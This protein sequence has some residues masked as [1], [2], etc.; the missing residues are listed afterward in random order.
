MKDLR[1]ITVTE[2]MKR[3][4]WKRG[5]VYRLIA[6]R[7]LRV[8]RVGRGR[9]DVIESSLEQLFEQHAGADV[10][11]H[12]ENDAEQAADAAVLALTPGERM[13]A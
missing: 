10:A 3:T 8:V 9:Q 7:H 13:F 4:N 12:I 5:K 1:T 11:R 2:V 6:S